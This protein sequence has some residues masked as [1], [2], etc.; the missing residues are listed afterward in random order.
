MSIDGIIE[1]KSVPEK[2]VLLNENIG[3]HAPHPHLDPET[4]AD[5]ILEKFHEIKNPINI[6]VTEQATEFDAENDHGI[7]GEDMEK[8]EE[9][10]VGNAVEYKEHIND[11]AV[12]VGTVIKKDSINFTIKIIGDFSNPGEELDIPIDQI[13]K[14]YEKAYTVPV[15]EE[16]EVEAHI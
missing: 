1:N 10:K 2:D 6:T 5:E 12:V 13:I 3:I 4:V 14:T 9:I 7:S 8:F 11:K 16:E 15:H